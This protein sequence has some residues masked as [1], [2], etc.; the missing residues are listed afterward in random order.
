MT[1]E[2]L[3]TTDFLMG[4]PPFDLLGRSVVTSV[5]SDIK[6]TY[7]R[8]GT[9]ILSPG[10]PCDS[11]YIIRS[12]ATETH[13][14]DGDLLARLSVGESFGIHA[15]MNKGVARNRVEAL[16]DT[17]MYLLPRKRFDQLRADHSSFAYF[18]APMGAERLRTGMHQTWEEQAEPSRKTVSSFSHRLSDM[19][20]GTPVLGMPDMSIQGAAQFMRDNKVS[21]L[22]IMEEGDLVGIV[23]DKD[24]R[25]RVVAD[26]VAVSD[27]VHSIMTPRPKVLQGDDTAF[28]ALVL[29]TRHAFRHVPVL[30]GCAPLGV[31]SASALLEW[32]A[33]SAVTIVKGVRKAASTTDLKPFMT[34]RRDLLRTM[35]E[36]GAGHDHVGI[37]LSAI[38]DT[39][40]VRLLELAE[41]MLGPPPLPY[42]WIALGEHARQE[43]SLVAALDHGVVL[44]DSYQITEHDDYFKALT[45]FVTAALIDLGFVASETHTS[46][47]HNECRQTSE[48]WTSQFQ[49]LCQSGSV[50]D[51]LHHQA[52]FD[53]RLIRGDLALF[54]D[55]EHTMTQIQQ[56]TEALKA[57]LAEVS[58][59]RA[60]PLGFFG[61]LVLVSSG[62]HKDTVNLKQ[63][64]LQLVADLARLFSVL[65]GVSTRPTKDQLLSLKTDE[66]PIKSEDVADLVRAFEIIGQHRLRLQADQLKSGQ[67][68]NDFLDPKQT[69]KF[70]QTHLKDAFAVIKALQSAVCDHYRVS[71][72][73][74]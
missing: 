12:G 25:N 43:Q 20:E 1:V 16:E 21:S 42:A 17:L 38:T 18:Y 15:M 57:P 51:V 14:P 71:V 36:A 2:L 73:T 24:L 33:P 69:S 13:S 52:L 34:Q 47:D 29:M 74:D 56:T 49:S 9:V 26:G 27:P 70:T 30:D 28:D 58:V 22:L 35:V 6:S 65:Q 37:A 5:V 40:T 59:K 60:P 61:H 64:G 23:T 7:A 4:H 48:V 67:E 50:T 45:A 31:I 55:F 46:A 66:L 62:E 11:L 63:Q 10:D 39:I 8:R 44:D 19:F 41:E 3:E 68:T 53:R 32:D 54:I 72:G